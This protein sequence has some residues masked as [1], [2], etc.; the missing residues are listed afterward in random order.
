MADFFGQFKKAIDQLL[1]VEVSFF[2]HDDNRVI[3]RK[4]VPLDFG[5]SRRSASNAK[6]YHLTDLQSDGQPGHPLSLL[7]EQISALKILDEHFKP[8]S[9][10]TWDLEKS[11]WFLPR[12]WGQFS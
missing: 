5:P 2:S 9:Y 12:D 6:K 11:P 1:L 3:T 7:P 10:I 8:V 4:C